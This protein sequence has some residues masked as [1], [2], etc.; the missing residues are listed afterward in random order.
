LGRDLGTPERFA[1][2]DVGRWCCNM[3]K[4]HKGATIM[5]Y[6]LIASALALVC[7][8]GFKSIGSKYTTI[9]NNISSSIPNGEP[10]T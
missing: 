5:E 9:Y 10:L 1:S 6:V 2:E 3:K 4:E 7:I 8:G